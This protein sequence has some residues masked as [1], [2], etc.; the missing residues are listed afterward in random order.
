MVFHANSY[1]P[2]S[3]PLSKN[4]E[5][6][7]KRGWVNSYDTIMAQ[8]FYSTRGLGETRKTL[9]FLIKSFLVKNCT[10]SIGKSLIDKVRSIWKGTNR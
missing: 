1:L 8:L 2:A 5:G 7:I 6:E 4:W 10:I 3:S 9:R